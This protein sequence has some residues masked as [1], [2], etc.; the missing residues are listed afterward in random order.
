MQGIEFRGANR[1]V[2][3]L[4]SYECHDTLSERLQPLEAIRHTFYTVCLDKLCGIHY[5]RRW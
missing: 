1:K 5:Q 4:V 3:L 2:V